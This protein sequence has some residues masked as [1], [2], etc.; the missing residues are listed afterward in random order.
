ML[1][2]YYDGHV[3]VLIWHN[4]YYFWQTQTVHVTSLVFNLSRLVYLVPL[5]AQFKYC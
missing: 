4:T 1:T 2:N 5:Y 3:S